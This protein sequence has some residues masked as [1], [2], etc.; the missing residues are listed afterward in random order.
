MPSEFLGTFV[1]AARGATESV[2]TKSAPQSAHFVNPGRYS[3]LQSGQNTSIT[4]AEESLC[5][6]VTLELARFEFDPNRF[7]GKRTR[8]SITWIEQ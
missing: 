5:A 3:A 7:G 4:S 2:A 8:D 1:S 6:I